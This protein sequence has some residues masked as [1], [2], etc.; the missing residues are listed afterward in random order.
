M[1]TVDEKTQYKYTNIKAL[2]DDCSLPEALTVLDLLVAHFAKQTKNP[3][4]TLLSHSINTKLLIL[5][6]PSP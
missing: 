2:L 5:V 4:D 3:L 1:T 6:E